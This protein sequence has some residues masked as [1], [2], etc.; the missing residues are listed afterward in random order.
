VTEAVRAGSTWLAGQPRLTAFL[1][2]MCIAFS[3][4]FFRFSGVSPSTATVFRCLY[5]LRLLLVL[6]TAE[7]RA[8]GRRSGRSLVPSW[9][10]HA[11][12]MALALISQVFGYGLISLSLPRLAAVLTSIVLVAQP[13]A[14]LVF[15]AILLA[16]APSSIQLAGVGLILGGV[17]IAVSRRDTRPIEPGA[18]APAQV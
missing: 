5:A 10:A 9:P 15:G 18:V 17:L 11:W 12:L 3:G 6:V 13:V 7:G 16:E 4:I 2:A 8:L 1:G 14:T